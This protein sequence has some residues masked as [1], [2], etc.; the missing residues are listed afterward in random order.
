MRSRIVLFGLLLAGAVGLAVSTLVAQ[1]RPAPERRVFTLDGRGSQIGVSVDDLDEQGLKAAG[2]AAGGVRIAEVD[3]N[4]PAAKAG[5]REGDIVVEVDGERIRSARQFSR[6]IQESPG[7]R[8]V[9]LGVVRDGKRQ[10][11]EVTPEARAFSFGSNA[12][13][14]PEFERQLRDIEPRLRELEPQLRDQLRNLEPFQREFRYGL[15]FDWNFD[16]LPRMTSPRGRLGVQVSE[17]TPQ[18]ADYFGVKD[19]GVLVSSVS[20]DSPAAKAGV[21]AGDIITSLNGGRIRD[22]DDL[23][24]EL[25]DK[26]GDVTIG[27]LREKKESTVKATLESTPTRRGLTRRPA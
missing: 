20:T 4:S 21:K 6:L 18:L 1:T 2:G 14:G 17:L 24:D 22:T 19:G 13:F 26:E 5:L 11:L 25:R 16:G 12:W 23:I 7:G 3:D 9:R 8:S 27:I 15:P 10:N